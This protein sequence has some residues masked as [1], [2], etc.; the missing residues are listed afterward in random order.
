[1]FIGVDQDLKG[2]G[3][4]LL[5]SP[6]CI[7]LGSSRLI[8]QPAAV[9]SVYIKHIFVEPTKSAGAPPGTQP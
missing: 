8:Y 9:I 1:M 5:L 6:M 3:G 2:V 4:E 7:E